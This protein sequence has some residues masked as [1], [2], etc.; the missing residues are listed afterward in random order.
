MVERMIC[1]DKDRLIA[2]LYGESDA[3][4]RDEVA[5]HLAVCGACAHEI[6]GMQEVRGHLSS[7]T[8]PDLALGFR[9][10]REAPSARSFWR[11]PAWGLAA[12][13]SLALVATVALAR[14]ELR[15][16]GDSLVVRSAWAAP[17]AGSA[18]GA[19]SLAS[20]NDRAA[21]LR[22]LAALEQRLRDELAVRPA[23][24]PARSAA[25]AAPPQDADVLRRVR[26]LIAES[27]RRQQQELALRLTQVVQ[28]FDRQRQVDLIRIQL[29]LGRL[30]GLT[31][32]EAAR[33][34]EALNYL[35]RVSQRPQ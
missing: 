15:F 4:E 31:G 11:L 35:I 24:A 12:A 25:T 8:P 6:E 33:Q 3:Q 19:G 10:V 32:A 7:W 17:A 22:E 9:V 21:V 2:Y 28:D 27:E 5:A 16:D 23:A 18:T 13:A 29:G 14:L 34:R 30:E 26:T 1:D 20:G